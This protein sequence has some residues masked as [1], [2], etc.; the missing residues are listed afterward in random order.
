MHDQS[1]IFLGKARVFGTGGRK[2]A[3]R[4]NIMDNIN[5]MSTCTNN[6]AT[7]LLWSKLSPRLSV[8]KGCSASRACK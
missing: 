8:A 4:L 6:N 3:M 1:L 7:M 2:K 5:S